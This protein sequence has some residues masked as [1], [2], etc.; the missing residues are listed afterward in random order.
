MRRAGSGFTLTELLVVIG[1]IA[2]L[3]GLIL[4]VIGSARKSAAAKVA[5]A[6]IERLKLACESYHADFGD[7]PPTSLAA[8]GVRTNG[9]NEGSE[10]LLRCL[11]TRLEHGPYFQYE[12]SELGNTDED[13]LGKTD[14]CS[15]VIESRSLYEI[16]DPWGNPYIYFHNRDYEGD[17]KL[18]K[19]VFANGDRVA[20]KPRR[21]EKTGQFPQITSF[22]IWSA[23][24]NGLNENGQ[25][26]DICSWK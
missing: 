20:C 12:E 6:T 3:A 17:P 9:L 14:P 11:T 13:A 7:Y 19:Y 2:L 8:L 10:S 4:P 16:V 1:I 24:P 21:S 23:G 22:L 18:Q 25:G 26:D 5:K 15:S